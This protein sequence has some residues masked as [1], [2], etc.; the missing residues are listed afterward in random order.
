MI[1]E[2]MNE[3]TDDDGSNKYFG[4]SRVATS[5]PV[6]P[7]GNGCTYAYVYS[8]GYVYIHRYNGTTGE[9]GRTELEHGRNAAVLLSIV[10][11][12]KNAFDRQGR[13][14]SLHPQGSSISL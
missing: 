2:R 10:L 3:P 9:D 14:S 1:Q 13:V 6:R 12:G 11:T 4:S 7:C 5:R 8:S